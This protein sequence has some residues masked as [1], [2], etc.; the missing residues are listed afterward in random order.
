MPVVTAGRL[1]VAACT[2]PYR[3]PPA[4]FGLAIWLAEQHVRARHMT[5]VTI[6]TPEPMPLAGVGGEAPAFMMAATGA[7]GVTVERGFTV[8]LERSDD[9][10]LR[11]DDGRELRYDAAFLIPPHERAPCLAGLPGAGPLVTVGERGRVGDTALYVVGDAAATG[12]PRAAGVASSYGVRAADGAL[13]LLGVCE[14][15]AIAPIEATCFM[16]HYGGAVSRIRVTYADGDPVVEID[17]PS[18]DLLPARAGEVR[19]FLAAART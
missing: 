13:E 12:L 6:A 7:A 3:C 19:R 15:P 1:V 8:D 14:A 10:V 17:G 4:P 9:G 18:L 5:R 2:L 11:A 16:F